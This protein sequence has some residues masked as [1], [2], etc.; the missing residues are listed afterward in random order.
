MDENPYSASGRSGDR[1]SHR[2]AWLNVAIATILGV[3]IGGSIGWTLGNLGG[4]YDPENVGFVSFTVGAAIG[5]ASA[6]AVALRRTTKLRL[7]HALLI[8]VGIGATLAA[9]FVLL[10]YRLRKP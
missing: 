1:W 5:L 6:T 3:T 9:G 8:G 10:V 2:A 7:G 4:R